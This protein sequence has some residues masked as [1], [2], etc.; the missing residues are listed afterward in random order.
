M[1]FGPVTA[2]FDLNAR[3]RTS[4]LC[5]AQVRCNDSL[6]MDFV[7]VSVHFAACGIGL[8]CL[9]TLDFWEFRNTPDFVCSKIRILQ[10]IHLDSS[11]MK[12][13]RSTGAIP[14]LA[15]E[16]WSRSPGA[17]RSLHLFPELDN[18]QPKAG[19]RQCLRSVGPHLKRRGCE[20]RCRRKVLCSGTVSSGFVSQIGLVTTY[21]TLPKNAFGRDPLRT[22]A[23]LRVCS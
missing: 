10:I 13:P 6:S 23:S 3:P 2:L 7:S 18:E 1:C 21:S 9:P 4:S 14:G 16:L 20:P 8:G 11:H 12:G 19:V 5:L 17:A 22:G 15:P